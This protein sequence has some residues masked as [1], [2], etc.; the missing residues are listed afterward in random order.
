MAAA[1]SCVTMTNVMVVLM[2]L[3]V[4][5]ITAKPLAEGQVADGVDKSVAITNQ[6]AAISQNDLTDL[7][8]IADQVG[9]ESSLS[10]SKNVS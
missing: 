6:A 8:S 2:M 7:T 1:M 3:V 4:A 5:E 10:V 9:V